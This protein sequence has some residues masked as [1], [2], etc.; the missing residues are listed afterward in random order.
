MDSTRSTVRALE[1]TR[2]GRI[3]LVTLSPL[4]AGGLSESNH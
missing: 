4:G 3:C 2:R 1:D